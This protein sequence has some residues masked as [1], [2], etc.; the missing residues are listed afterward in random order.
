MTGTDSENIE[1]LDMDFIGTS[2]HEYSWM[3]DFSRI[4][5][6]LFSQL[7]FSKYNILTL[8]H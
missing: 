7:L 5:V 4:K 6:A 3:V 8:V 2:E 1:F